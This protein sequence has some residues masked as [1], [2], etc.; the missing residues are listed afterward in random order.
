MPVRLSVRL[1]VCLSVTLMNQSKTVVVKIKQFSCTVATSHVPLFLQ[2][3]FHSKIMT[4]S[5]SEG[6]KQCV[7]W[8]MGIQAIL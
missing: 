4:S 8:E 2:D 6:V 1:S 5:L 7:G 3:N